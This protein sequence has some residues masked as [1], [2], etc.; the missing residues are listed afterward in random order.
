MEPGERG[1]F[2]TEIDGIEPG[3]AYRY[4]LDGRE[5]AD[6]ASRFQPEGVHGPSQVVAA[7]FDWRDRGW[8]GLSLSDLVVYELHVGTYTAD[9]TFDA[10]IAHLDELDELGVTAIELMPVGAFPGSR[11]W[12]YDG[13]FP[14]AVQ[15]SYGG[16]VSL[17]RL[18]DECHG[19]GMGLVLDVVYNHLGPEGAVLDHFGPYFTDRYRTPW[20]R[21]VNFDGPGS[22]EVRRFFIENALQWLDEF[23]VD[24]LRLDAVHGIVD[25]SAYPFIQELADTIHRRSRELDRSLL[26]IGE[27]DLNDSRLVTEVGRGGLGLDAQWSDDFHHALHALVTG[28]RQGY[29]ADFGEVEHL[30]AALREG[31]VYSG[32]YSAFRGRRFG[33]SSAGIPAER[34]VVYA[35]NHDQVGNRFAGERLSSLLSFEQLKLV[36]GAVLL[37]PFV[38]L[39]FMGEEYGELA[40]FNYFISHSDPALI[41]SVRRGRA[42]E[43]AAFDW[44]G[45]SLDPHD[46]AAFFGSKLDH[47]LKEKE[48][49]RL[50]LDLYRELLRLRRDIPALR[51]SS[52]EELEVTTDEDARMLVLR[53]WTDDQEAFIVSNFGESTDERSVERAVPAGDGWTTLLDS[54]DE[55]WGGPGQEMAAKRRG[56]ETVRPHSFVLLVRDRR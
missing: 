14:F 10:L 31:F 17:K 24:A 48:P 25:T 27:S 43:F 18:V 5:L 55:R 13:V 2:E 28:E 12:G 54:A 53:R 50:L 33:S 15:A 40:P 47:A 51:N 20:G 35:Q 3:T 9:G 22:D 30:A 39:L 49:H 46:E 4:R 38:P 45:D 23:H 37:S 8:R 29:Y 52:K 16:P 56:V 44:E 26:L 34:L 7:D 19:R 41:E 1:Y 42:A 11:N 32:Q 21:A 6:P 36:A